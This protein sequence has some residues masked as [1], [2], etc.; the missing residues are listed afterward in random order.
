MAVLTDSLRMLKPEQDLVE[1]YVQKEDNN[2]FI[3]MMMTMTM[4]MT[5][6]IIIDDD[7]DDDDDD[8]YD[9]YDK[10][11]DAC[12]DNGFEGGFNAVAG[13]NTVEC[14][15]AQYQYYYYIAVSS[16]LL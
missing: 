1:T 5:M 11:D 12:S 6:I 15:N 2:N 9:C 10:P 4:T 13:I 16:N 14:V 3:L 7:D 8:N